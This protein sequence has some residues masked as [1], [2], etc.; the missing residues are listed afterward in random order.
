MIPTPRSQHTGPALDF[1]PPDDKKKEGHNF[2]P[3]LSFFFHSNGRKKG[4]R[5]KS[6]KRSIHGCISTIRKRK[7][8][9][10]GLAPLL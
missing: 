1:D 7:S 5:K 9:N 6:K 10:S 8:E 2:P 4:K 3:S